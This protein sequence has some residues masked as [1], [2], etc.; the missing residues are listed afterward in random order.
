M[1]D[2][3]G[4]DTGDPMGDA[5]GLGLGVVG[6][7]LSVVHDVLS[8]GLFG[9]GVGDGRVVDNFILLWEGSTTSTAILLRRLL[10]A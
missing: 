4:E 1:C 6:G 2:P 5:A 9:E 3:V 7:D 8:F 10:F